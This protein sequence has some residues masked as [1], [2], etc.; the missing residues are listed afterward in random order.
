V[1][2]LKEQKSPLLAG[3]CNSAPVFPNSRTRGPFRQKSPAT[4]ANIPV[5]QK[6]WAE[7]GFYHDCRPLE[8]LLSKDGFAVLNG[9]K[10][11]YFP[12]NGQQT[13]FK[14]PVQCR[15]LTQ[16]LRELRK[17]HSIQNAIGRCFP[18]AS[19]LDTPMHMVEFADRMGIRIY[20]D[21]APAIERRLMPTPVE[22]SRQGWALISTATS[23]LAQVR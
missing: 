2:S 22:I 11:I 20:A 3:F 8:P 4:T 9:G 1:P 14:K 7:T 5:L 16:I 21:H 18:L 12:S 19:H 10:P 15:Y 23:C 13:N 6:L 17:R